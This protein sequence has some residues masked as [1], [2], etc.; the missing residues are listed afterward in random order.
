MTTTIPTPPISFI[1]FTLTPS[2]GPAAP[3][4][5]LPAPRPLVPPAKAPSN[6][7]AERVT[8]LDDTAYRLL[9]SNPRVRAYLWARLGPIRIPR[10]EKEDLIGTTVEVLWQR[11]TSRDPART[12]ARV[13]GL[14]KTVLE[15][16]LVD[17]WRHQAI[18]DEDIV[19]APGPRAEGP[20]AR[21]KPWDQ[22]TY[23][24]EVRPPRSFTP[25]ETLDAKQQM[26]HVN[27]VAAKI[28]L[29]DDDVEDMYAMAWDGEATYEEL[30]AARGMTPG[31]LRTRLHRLQK[32]VREGWDR[33]VKRTLILTLLLLAMLL[34]YVLAAIGP[35]R[36]PP[37][38]PAPLP[39]PTVNQVAPVAPT[40][41]TQ[42]TPVDDGTGRKP[43]H[44][45]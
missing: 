43:P 19:D 41:T 3:P 8:P 15:G 36:N 2:T 12:L 29:T 33:R 1:P 44:V 26:Q 28:G 18:V 20:T 34:L 37:P 14:A 11:R 5:P 9:L 25:E 23:V 40:A 24:E 7:D 45:R 16:K 13:L 35:A 32:A 22:P 10:Q 31:A 17:Y 4:A 6:D 27:E 30:A 38:P 21:G 42:A 39:E